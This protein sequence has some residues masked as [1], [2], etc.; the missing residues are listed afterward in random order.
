MTLILV[1]QGLYAGYKDA[2]ASF[3]ERLPAE[4][5]VPQSGPM[6]TYSNG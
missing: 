4:I 3:I 6:S 5:L 1:V 2:F